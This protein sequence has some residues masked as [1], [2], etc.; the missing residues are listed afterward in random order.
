MKCSLTLSRNNV[1]NSVKLT[2]AHRYA[3]SE[4]RTTLRHM[5]DPNYLINVYGEH[6]RADIKSWKMYFT[7][8][9]NEKMVFK[10]QDTV[11]SFYYQNCL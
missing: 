2:V 7:I 3:T 1:P 6:F 4:K 5:L 9:M 10:Q 11:L 8:E